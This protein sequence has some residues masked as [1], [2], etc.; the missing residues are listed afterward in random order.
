MATTLIATA[1]ALMVVGAIVFAL[2]RHQKLT[3]V[4]GAIMAASAVVIVIG[5]AL[6]AIGAIQPASAETTPKG[7]SENQLPERVT[8]FQLPTL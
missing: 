7:L 3:V 1:V 8:D 6:A 2:E 4:T 5:S